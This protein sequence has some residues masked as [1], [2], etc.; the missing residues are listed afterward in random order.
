[1]N[2]EELWWYGPTWLKNPDQW[3]DEIE[4]QPTAE[5]NAEVKP[6]KSVFAVAV[7]DENEADEILKKFHFHKALRVYA[8]MQRFVDNSRSRTADVRV[9][10][11]LT[12][13][14]IDRQR[15]FYLKRAQESSDIEIDR[16]ALNLQP[17]N[18]GLLECCGRIQG[19][20]PVYIPDG[21][22]MSQRIV[23]ETHQ[24]T[25]HEEVSLIMAYVRT[26]YWM[27]RLRRLVKKIRKPTTRTE[28]KNAFQ[29]IGV[30]FAGPLKYQAEKKREE[31][32]IFFF[33]LVA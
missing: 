16:V 25:L 13:N 3:P 30:D 32:L 29:V 10:G 9:T 18:D 8:W 20:Y 24:N 26:R 5:S 23:E 12:A 17:R 33:M 19:K 22:L 14:E 21:H 1:M 2:N 4:L 31:K 11:P 15:Q 7:N 6:K 27:P 28:G